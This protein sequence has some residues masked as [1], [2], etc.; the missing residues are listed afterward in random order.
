MG[1]FTVAPIGTV[2]AGSATNIGSI[3]TTT[4]TIATAMTTVALAIAAK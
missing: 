1:E 4:A 2:K 3:A